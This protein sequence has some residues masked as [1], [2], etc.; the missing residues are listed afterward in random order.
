MIR[1]T[2]DM[3]DARGKTYFHNGEPFNGVGFAIQEKL[4]QGTEFRNGLAVGQY[5]PFCALGNRGGLQVDL[6]VSQDEPVLYQGKRFTGIGYGFDHGFCVYECSV[7]NGLVYSEA[8]WERDGWMSSC[9]LSNEIFSESYQ[10]YAPGKL[11]SAEISTNHQ[12]YGSFTFAEDGTLRALSMHRAF[13]DSL[14]QICQRSAFDPSLI[15][16]ARWEDLGALRAARE[17]YLSGDDIDDRVLTLMAA[18]GVFEKTVK[19]KIASVPNLR[20]ADLAG[21]PPSLKE[22][23][24]EQMEP[25]QIHIARELK[26]AMPQL[27]VFFN[28]TEVTRNS[29]EIAPLT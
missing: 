17:I 6:S 20:S 25:G 26:N 23:H 5:E 4:V 12:Y 24:F 1:L 19:L 22:A 15:P 13:L 11:K 29:V 3:L 9:T 2:I 7:A 14:N 21:C 18:Q 28:K 16:I 10:W 27:Q 8:H